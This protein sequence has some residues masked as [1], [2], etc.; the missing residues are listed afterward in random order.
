M[1]AAKVNGGMTEPTK[2]MRVAAMGDLHVR[3]DNESS[4]RDL[5]GEISREADVLVLAG[6]LTDLGKPKEAE[7][8]AQDLKACSI[9]VIGVL[10]NHDYECGAHEEVAHILRDAGMRVLDG[11]SCEIDGVG[12]VGVKGFAGGFGRRMLGSFGEPAI[13]QFVGEAMNETLRLENAMRQVK[14]KRSVVIL[15]YAPVT[16]TI[17]SEPL[18]IYPFLGSSRLAET[19]DRF[20]VSA[21]VHGHA[22]RGRYEGRTPGGQPVYNVARHIEK[23]SGKPYGI[24]EI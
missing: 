15:H 12:F 24:L 5:F 23:P 11:Q 16:D 3:E 19:I 22:H 21:I 20:K 4:Y 17:E 18:E 7:L 6:D 10:G 13:K 2:P 1:W 9:P 8:L 14:A